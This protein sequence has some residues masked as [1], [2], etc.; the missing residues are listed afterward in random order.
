MD[1]YFGL[2]PDSL[3]RPLLAS[4]NLADVLDKVQARSNLGVASADDVAKAANPLGTI[5]AIYGST[6]PYG[7]L[8]CEGQ[9]IYRDAFPDLVQF[10]NPG[11][12]SA[13]L[14]DLR[15]EFLRGWD[16]GRGID[17][18]RTIRSWQNYAFQSHSHEGTVLEAGSHLHS[19]T[20][21]GGAHAHTG[22]VA[23]AGGHTHSAT[24]VAGGGHTHTASTDQAGSH[25]HAASSAMS[26]THSHSGSTA[27]AG[28]HIHAA[29]TDS[30]G[31]HQHATSQG[32]SSFGGYY[33]NTGLHNRAGSSHGADSDNW[34][35]LT[36]AA[37]AHTHNIGISS[38]G[39]H[40]HAVT[41][42]NDGYHNHTITVTSNGSHVHTLTVNSVA[43]HTHGV[44]LAAVDNHTHALTVDTST[45]HNHDLSINYAGAHT[46]ALSFVAN[47]DVETRPRNVAVM[48]CIKAYSSAISDTCL[49]V[50][51]L[52]NGLPLKVDL[53]AFTGQNQALSSIGY[54]KIPGGLIL[55]WGSKTIT[56]PAAV[57]AS[58]VV[59]TDITFPVVF[60]TAVVLTTTSLM[61]SSTNLESVENNC[62]VRSRTLT[63]FTAEMMRMSGTS[64]VAETVTIQWM[65]L[66]Y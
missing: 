40:A 32:Y 36:S 65:A 43:D 12:D 62:G 1:S 10:L 45:T 58:G 46:H 61:S 19:G 48:F 55:Q 18:N 34:E 15:G 57:L 11:F 60:P 63:G 13:V 25:G 56:G 31:N 44:T 26:G 16:H 22:S 6:V 66:G 30:Q 50:A 23:G 17:K 29:S 7:Y 9:I 8:A 5:I 47:G 42:A 20:A 24:V 35:Y 51:A 38:A 3:K 37:G 2:G 4:E 49:N 52:A 64:A 41:V 21:A 39:D 54:Q 33:G 59:T 14:P 28:A 27:T 53:A